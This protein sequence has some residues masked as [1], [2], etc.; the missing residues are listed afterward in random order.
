MK[1]YTA[2]LPKFNL[3]SG[4]W[5][6][7]R[8]GGRAVGRLPN[9]TQT[10][11]YFMLKCPLEGLWKLKQLPKALCWTWNSMYNFPVF[12]EQT[13][14]SSVSWSTSSFVTNQLTAG[15]HTAACNKN[16]KSG[17]EP[18][19]GFLLTM[20]GQGPEREEATKTSIWLICSTLLVFFGCQF[21]KIVCFWK[22]KRWGS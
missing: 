10:A 20:S 12:P 1:Y 14:S 11:A 8:S 21:L 15:S 2:T 5:G 13:S 4:S 9:G 18:S 17:T 22:K 7:W 3:G 16:R 6:G 19:A